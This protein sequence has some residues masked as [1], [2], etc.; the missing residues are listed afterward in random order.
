MSTPFSQPEFLVLVPTPDLHSP[1]E[2][3]PPVRIIRN[4]RWRP[5]GPPEPD[6][7]DEP[8]AYERDLAEHNRKRDLRRRSTQLT[9]DLRAYGLVV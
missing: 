3:R 7:Y 4:P 1:T 2:D 5:P 6:D 8:G 9:N